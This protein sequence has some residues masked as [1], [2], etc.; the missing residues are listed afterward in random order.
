MSDEKPQSAEH[1]AHDH[2][3]GAVPDALGSILS[4]VC[5]IHCAATPF[6]L[7]AVP[8]ISPILGLAHPI[9]VVLVAAV[10]LWAFI[11]GYRCHRRK[12]IFV[13][14]ASG[15]T[16]LSV[17]AFFAVHDSVVDV[18]LTITGVLTMLVTHWYNRRLIRQAHCSSAKNEVV[19][20]TSAD[21]PSK[22]RAL[23]TF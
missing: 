17:G 12:I 4:I 19:S 20:S 3:D 10:A 5:G 8:T 21:V 13:G 11:P 7:I 9:F 2:R 15:L 6:I 14:A 1:H 18:V 16:L 23:S 22:D